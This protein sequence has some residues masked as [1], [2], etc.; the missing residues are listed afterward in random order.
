MYSNI[1][2]KQITTVQCIP[3]TRYRK[4]EYNYVFVSCLR[5][6]PLAGGI[7]VPE[8]IIGSIVSGHVL[9]RTQCSSTW[10]LIWK[11]FSV[12]SMTVYTQKPLRVKSSLILSKNV[13]KCMVNSKIRILLSWRRFRT[14]TTATKTKQI[15]K[16]GGQDLP[17]IIEPPL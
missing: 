16:N 2:L 14:T 7:L 17:M 10:R 9:P 12:M 11:W 8:G 1:P 15:F 3:Q 6:I 5:S 4:I 13:Q